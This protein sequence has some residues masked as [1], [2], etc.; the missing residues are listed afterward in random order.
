M[1]LWI[2]VILSLCLLWGCGDPPNSV[3]EM[4]LPDKDM[5]AAEEPPPPVTTIADAKT[6]PAQVMPVTETEE[7]PVTQEV[8]E[9]PPPPAEP[10]LAMEMEAILATEGEVLSPIPDAV[11][12][13]LWGHW[14]EAGSLAPRKFYKK[15]IDADGIAIV[16]SENVDNAFFQMA[17]HIVLVM[18]SKVPSVREALS[19]NQPG[20]VGGE[21]VPFRLVLTNPEAQDV[22]NMPENLNTQL[23]DIKFWVGSF[24]GYFARANVGILGNDGNFWGH[25]TIMHEMVHAMEYAIAVRNL[26][27]NF[28]QRLDTAWEREEEKIRI[29]TEID[30]EPY[31]GYTKDLPEWDRPSYCVANGNSHD[32][33]SEFLARFADVFWWDVMFNPTRGRDPNSNALERHREICPNLIGVL[34]EIFPKFS[35]HFA[36]E[37]RGYEAE[38]GRILRR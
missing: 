1:R 15:F 36:V 18:T 5:P 25:Q 13:Q 31:P 19:I 9:E 20:G 12:E 37:T 23:G 29:R 26:V 27:P 8:E 14:T 16:G 2:C 4:V 30:G 10:S 11:Y 38:D 22:V 35:L 6:P 17:R 21:D 7:P 24:A 28:V 34:E 3:M 32:N 33:A